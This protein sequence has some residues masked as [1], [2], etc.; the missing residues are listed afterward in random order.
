VNSKSFANHLTLLCIS[1]PSIFDQ[2]VIF[3]DFE[4]ILNTGLFLQ[5]LKYLLDD[6]NYSSLM[7]I[8]ILTLQ[9]EA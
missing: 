8:I 4:G 6:S 5:L 3:A 7:A 1:A 2:S 9:L